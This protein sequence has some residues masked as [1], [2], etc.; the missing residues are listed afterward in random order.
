M[1]SIEIGSIKG[2]MNFL[3]RSKDFQGEYYTLKRVNLYTNQLNPK[4]TVYGVV[5]SFIENRDICLKINISLRSYLN[6]KNYLDTHLK[7]GSVFSCFDLM[8]TI[9][10]HYQLN[11][12]SAIVYQYENGHFK[13]CIVMEKDENFLSADIYFSDVICIIQKM[14][15]PIFIN[16]EIVHHFGISPEEVASFLAEG[17]IDL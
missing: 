8:G 17:R 9:S 16:K 7:K 6:I 13:T 14:K 12:I 5:C 15:M 1:N 10:N 11:F 4:D 2:L 3:G